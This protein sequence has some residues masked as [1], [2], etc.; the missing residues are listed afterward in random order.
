MTM[1]GPV[2]LAAATSTPA[3]LAQQ[4]TT[5]AATG[6]SG[7]LVQATLGLAIVLALIWGAAWLVRRLA[8][9]AG[10]VG[11]AIRI[12][13]AQSVGPRERVVLIEVGEQWL[14]VGVA[15]GQVNA[16]QA[17]PKGAVPATASPAAGAFGRILSRA[18]G[19]SRD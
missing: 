4:A 1:R 6:L 18:R 5:A 3:A 19:A 15:P 17:L 14:L 12:V 10:S 2:A 13:A 9:A 11:S 16:L 7:G 8:P